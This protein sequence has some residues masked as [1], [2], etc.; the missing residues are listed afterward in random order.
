VAASRQALVEREYR[1]RVFRQ[2][3]ALSDWTTG[4]GGIDVLNWAAPNPNDTFLDYELVSGTVASS[5]DWGLVSDPV[6]SKVD[7]GLASAPSSWPPPS[8]TMSNL[9]LAGTP[10]LN[11]KAYLKANI[12]GGERFDWFYFNSNNRERG[13]DPRGSD[14]QVS[15]P[16]FPADDRVA[17]SRNPFFAQ[18]QILGH[19]QLRWWWNNTHQ[20]LYDDGLGGGLL[21]HGN[22]TGWTANAKS[23]VFTEYGYPACDKCTSQ[24]NVFFGAGSSE[25]GT[26]YWSIWDSADGGG[27]LPRAN[28]NL[29]L[30]ALQA[31]YEYWFA[32]GHNV[33]APSGLKMIQPAF[34]SVWNWDA[35]PF[36]TFPNLVSVWGDAGNWQAGN[37]LNGKGPFLVPPVPDPP[38]GVPVPFTFP[39][40]PGLA[41]S[42]HK[43]PSFSTRV[44][45]HVSGREVRCHFTPSHCTSSS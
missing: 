41:F 25:S 19:K 40:L 22:A 12:E 8:S 36:P 44:A 4:T 23:I 26:P 37:W 42:V 31:I 33:V 16:G 15:G 11:S 30:L 29:S 14:L 38:A 45:S 1:P 32:D 10:A 34:C 17:Q 2:L 5:L 13:L 7:Y 24:P 27:Y 28:Q 35:R 43:K 21:P 20:L 18:Q 3:P 9:G 39:A 6:A